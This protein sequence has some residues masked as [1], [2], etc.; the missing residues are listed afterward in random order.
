MNS[1]LAQTA[2]GPEAQA[3]AEDTRTLGPTLDFMRVLWRV[4][5]ALQSAS[6]KLEME[7]GITGPQRLVLRILSRYPGASAGEL[8]ELLHLHPSTLTGVLQRLQARNLIQRKAD[9]SDARRALFALSTKG[10]RLAEVGDGAI[11]AA[12]RRVTELMQT[13]SAATKALL[14]ALASELEAQ[15]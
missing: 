8:A 11:D 6:K 9:P 7:S 12:V 13:E 15:R 4:D 3:P 1:P 2:V 14:T 5:H 10:K